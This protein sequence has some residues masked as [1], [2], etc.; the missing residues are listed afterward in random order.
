[1]LKVVLGGGDN[2]KSNIKVLSN[3][4][5]VI[6]NYYGPEVKITSGDILTTPNKICNYVVGTDKGNVK[7]KFILAHN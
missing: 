7:G 6:Q 1:M 3:K 2:V 4:D 5:E